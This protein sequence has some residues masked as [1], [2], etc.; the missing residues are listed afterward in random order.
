MEVDGIRQ[1]ERPRKTWWDGVR[2][3]DMKRFG[4]SREDARDQSKQRTK[5]KVQ[6]E[7]GH[8]VFCCSIIH[9]T[10]RV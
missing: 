7:D 4:L 5:V 3:D 2:K 10:A 8:C 9:I 1:R 6:L